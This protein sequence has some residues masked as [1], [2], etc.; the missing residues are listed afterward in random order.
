MLHDSSSLRDHAAALALRY[1]C[2]P[3]QG[4]GA[5]SS[6]RS[7]VSP[8]RP[9]RPTP[10]GGAPWSPAL[11]EAAPTY[12]GSLAVM[13]PSV[14][15]APTRL[16]PQRPTFAQ[17]AAEPTRLSARAQLEPTAEPPA[18]S[19]GGS[20]VWT[21]ADSAYVKKSVLTASDPAT[22][23]TQ[24]MLDFFKDQPVRLDRTIVTSTSNAPRQFGVMDSEL[25][26]YQ[27]QPPQD[28]S[29]W[30]DPSTYH[31][32][33]RMSPPRRHPNLVALPL[34]ASSRDGPAALSSG[35]PIRPFNSNESLL[36]TADT[37]LGGRS[38]IPEVSPLTELKIRPSSSSMV[39]GSMPATSPSS[40][41][42]ESATAAD[43][44][45]SSGLLP[46]GSTH[47]ATALS[48]RFDR[49]V[50][51]RVDDVEQRVTA[52]QNAHVKLRAQLAMDIDRA[53]YDSEQSDFR[54][55]EIETALEGIVNALRQRLQSRT[56]TVR[57]LRE[58]TSL[59]VT[60]ATQDSLRA[61]F[62]AFESS[63]SAAGQ[64]R[65]D[66]IQA[67][68]AMMKQLATH[69]D[70][71]C[72]TLHHS[73]NARVQEHPAQRLAVVKQGLLVSA[74]GDQVSMQTMYQ[75]LQSFVSQTEAQ[76]QELRD[77]RKAFEQRYVDRLE[78][79]AALDPRLQRHL[80]TS[81]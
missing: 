48:T 75:M 30:A 58:D 18:A 74:R 56:D 52:H 1:C 2:N 35:S 63:S 72:A 49:M 8:S 4:T 54:L 67:L 81:A 23:R 43:A 20:T 24:A 66:Q 32:T 80:T 21:K 55:L 79:L 44:G 6:S 78:Q 29:S 45:A 33:G 40:G 25:V 64:E 17:I 12:S 60:S 16:P 70:V 53:R 22:N 26:S 77:D 3:P 46:V 9:Q 11:S 68:D 14:N 13:S 50:W 15:H 41:L 5:A 62:T 10:S 59:Q 19:G 65:N 73:L 38:P 42:N 34:T 61:Q 76:L 7:R 69:L 36:K 27:Q 47:A 28:Q 39:G 71:K 57:Q 31:S 37:K 51:Q